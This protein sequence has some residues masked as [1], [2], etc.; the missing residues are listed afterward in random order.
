[1]VVNFWASWC[2]SCLHEIPAFVKLYESHRSEVSFLGL[3]LQ[4]DRD[5]AAK[6]ARE[7]GITY[8]LGRDPQGI[9]F[10]AFGGVVMPT[11]VILDAHGEI[12]KRLD[13]EVSAEQLEAELLG[14]MKENG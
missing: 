3:N 7:L 6:L 5:A 1:M 13:G 11:T 14:L 9:A 12:L 8:V 2:T 10:Q 4:D